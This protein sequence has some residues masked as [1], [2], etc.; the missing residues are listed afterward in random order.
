MPPSELPE[1][2]VQ[3]FQASDYKSIIE[4][5]STSGINRLEQHPQA[6]YFAA[7][8]FYREQMYEQSRRCL[9][10]LAPLSSRDSALLSF[11][12]AV[13]RRL[14]D[15]AIS[16]QAL[17]RACELS[18]SDPAVQNNY[19]NLLIDLGR[20]D[21]SREILQRLLRDNPDYADANANLQRLSRCIL[22]ASGQITTSLDSKNPSATPN[23]IQPS[24]TSTN[25]EQVIWS[26]PDPLSLA[27]SDAE[28]SD[29][30]SHEAIVKLLAGNLKR[31]LRQLPP[32]DAASVEA[33]RLDMAQ[34]AVDES[35]PKLALRI[36]SDLHQVQDIP[37][38][39]LYNILF[40]AYLA[41]KQ[42]FQAEI[43]LLHSLVIGEASVA[44]M[45][46]LSSFAMMRHDYKLAQY[47]YNR[48]A[49]LDPTSPH[50]F[51]LEKSLSTAA[52]QERKQ[53]D[54][55]SPA[56]SHPELSFEAPS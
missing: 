49:E 6:S 45:I 46:N 35:S 51:E 32:V 20:Y 47:Y 17:T 5:V 26:P 19:A 15:F 12:G 38:P 41:L 52:I 4:H 33:E 9:E 39:R 8:A 13:C 18:P 55:F 31:L 25:S 10:H 43:C 7:I 16:F 42:P 2:T 34:L 30:A 50:L 54:C 48:A 24:S 28:V 40:N 11:Y 29:I 22:D 53:D 44:S 37:C 1:L 36:C 21:E 14:N 3:L 27:F 56:W 23:S